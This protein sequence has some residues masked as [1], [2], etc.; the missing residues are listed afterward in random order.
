MPSQVP[1]A[2]RSRPARTPWWSSQKPAGAVARPKYSSRFAATISRQPGCVRHASAIRHM[3]SEAAENF[4]LARGTGGEQP[5]NPVALD[6]LGERRLETRAIGDA[7]VDLHPRRLVVPAPERP[8]A[9]A[10]RRRQFS[11]QRVDRP[12]GARG[13]T[14]RH[15]VV[16]VVAQ[17]HATP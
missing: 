4:L 11:L 5:E 7:F 8:P 2:S 6:Q 10:R 9:H 1:P 3:A 15:A 14:R 16:N 13:V 17:A 12:P